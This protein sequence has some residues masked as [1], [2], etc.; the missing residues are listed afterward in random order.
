MNEGGEHLT[1]A[2]PAPEI[3]VNADGT[4]KL[5]ARHEMENTLRSSSSLSTQNEDSLARDSVRF[6]ALVDLLATDAP[7]SRDQH[8][9]EG[10][11]EII[12]PCAL[13]TLPELPLLVARRSDPF[14]TPERRPNVSDEL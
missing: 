12:H 1:A 11:A 6:D 14:Q 13:A 9:G 3:S 5:S 8:P 2:P 10:T 4:E 7:S